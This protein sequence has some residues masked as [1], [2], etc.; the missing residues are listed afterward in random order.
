MDGESGGLAHGGP[1]GFESE[2][3][4]PDM[5]RADGDGDEEVGDFVG[6]D[7]AVGDLEGRVGDVEF[8]EVLSVEA[9]AGA[10][11]AVAVVG[12]VADGDAVFDESD[13]HVVGGEAGVVLGED[14]LADHAA[15]FADVELFG[16]VLVVG[17]FVFAKAP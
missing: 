9:G 15:G 10:A 1:D 11:A 2:G 4:E 14:M 12:V 3:P 17:P 8:A 6:D 13:A 16:E 7:G 5:T